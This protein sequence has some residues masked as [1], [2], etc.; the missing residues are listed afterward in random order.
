MTI[1]VIVTTMNQTDHSLLEKMNIQSDAIICNQ[2]DRYEFEEFIYRGYNIKWFSFAE[3][4]VGLNRNNGLM[5]ATADIVLFADDDLV[6]VDG[7]PEIIKE[8]F[9]N[10]KEADIF[11]L[12]LAYR[13]KKVKRIMKEEKLS[14]RKTMRFGGARI[15]ARLSKL[16]LH[17]L[18]FNLCFGGGTGFSSGEDTL[19]LKDCI[20]KGLKIYSYPKLIASLSDERESTWFRGY[21]SKFFRDKGILFYLLNNKLAVFFAFYHCFKHRDL[22]KGYGWLNGFIH[23]TKGINA[24]K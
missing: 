9:S 17:G 7:Y 4:G 11:I 20:S 21:N 10:N 19:F 14:F 13:N 15:C 6:Y 2:C 22:Y 1:Q 18:S 12:D 24:M 3:R 5:R 8:A 16:R 23:M